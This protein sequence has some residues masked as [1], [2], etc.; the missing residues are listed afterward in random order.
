MYFVEPEGLPLRVLFTVPEEGWVSWIGT[1]KQEQSEETGYRY[2]G[3]SIVNVTNLVVDGCMDH[4]AMAP[5]VG[6]TVDD[7]ASAMAALPPFVISTAP[8][9]IDAYGYHGKHLELT[10]PELALDVTG[11]ESSFPECTGGELKSWIGAPLSYAFYGYFEPGQREELW[12]LDVDGNRLVVQASWS[13][14]SP[15]EDVDV[16]RTILASIE[17]ETH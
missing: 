11:R 9:D 17:V 14:D 1:F 12:I 3:I 7:L 8:S 15:P 16:M 2:V 4:G 13:P 6:P 5:A 10:V